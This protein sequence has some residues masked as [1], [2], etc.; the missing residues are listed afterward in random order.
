LVNFANLSYANLI[1]R[2]RQYTLVQQAAIAGLIILLIYIPY[3]YFLLRLSIEESIIMAIYSALLFI[4]V[5]YIT[6]A[7]IT[8]K[9]KKFIKQSVGPKKGLRK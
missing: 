9:T 2:F 4:V 1:L 3:S 5:Y 8:R 7:I 6:S